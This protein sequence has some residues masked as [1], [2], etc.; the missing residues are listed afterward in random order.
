MVDYIKTILLLGVLSAF[1]V[2]LGGFFFGRD[3]LY[4]A[5]IFSLLMNGVAYFFSEKIAIASSGAKPLGDR[6]PKVYRMV[7]E[8]SRRMNIP[9]PKLYLIPSAQ[10]N[11][12]AT[13]RDP[14]HSSI[15]VT[16]GI[17]ETLGDEELK[18]VIAH[19]LGHVKNRDILIASVAAVLASSI[20]FVSRMGMYGGSSDNN[21]RHA[22]L[23]I[24]LAL[25]GPLAAMIIQMAVSRNREFEADETAAETMGNGEPLAQ[26]LL[27]IE[28][29]VKHNKL[30]TNPAFSSLYISN[31]FG[32]VGGAL[33]KLFST[34]PPT[35]E[36]VK[37]L[38]AMSI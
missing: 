1:F 33:M 15:A 6:H 27:K 37:R 11:A 26:A 34:H 21:N 22:G 35:A 3:G 20:A 31:P 12:F 36:R 32:G 7:E 17:I 9:M 8:L 25:L 13:G 29:S 38:M 23:G 16:E 5:F 19:E 28:T 2:L 24:L 18:S 10:A 4:M 30:N 14:N